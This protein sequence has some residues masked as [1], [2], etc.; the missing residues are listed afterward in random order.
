VNGQKVNA[1]VDKYG[2]PWRNGELDTAEMASSMKGHP[3]DLATLKAYI[4]AR[5][6]YSDAS[7]HADKGP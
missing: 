3:E 4:T 6:A 1:L 7:D 2:M 5:Q